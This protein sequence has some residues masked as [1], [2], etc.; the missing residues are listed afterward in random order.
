M[1][2][3]KGRQLAIAVTGVNDISVYDGHSPYTGTGNK[4][5]SK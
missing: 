3:G 4:F 2:S 1:G 5:G